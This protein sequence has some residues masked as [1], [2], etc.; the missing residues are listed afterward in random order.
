MEVFTMAVISNTQVTALIFVKWKRKLETTY[1]EVSS[2]G[3]GSVGYTATISSHLHTPA[4]GR[5]AGGRPKGGKNKTAPQTSVS[6]IG[7]P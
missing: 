2:N 5:R 3:L 7:E 6:N 4:K 1:N